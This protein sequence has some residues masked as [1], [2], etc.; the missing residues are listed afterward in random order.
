VSIF[1]AFMPVLKILTFV[2]LKL[3][4]IVLQLELRSVE[5]G[6]AKVILDNS[7]YLGEAS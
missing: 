1:K 7:N 4:Q 5:K 2:L 3:T 6:I